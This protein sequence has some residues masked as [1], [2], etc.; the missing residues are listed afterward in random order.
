[1]AFLITLRPTLMVQQKYDHEAPFIPQVGL[2]YVRG[3]E[4]EGM[5]DAE[6]KVIE[7]GKVKVTVIVMHYYHN[8]DSILYQGKDF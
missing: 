2:V 5:L 7:E 4:V 6:G 3:C 1:M 8:Y